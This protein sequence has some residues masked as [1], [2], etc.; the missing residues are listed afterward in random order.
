MSR[1]IDAI[2]L[3]AGKG[4]RVGQKEPKQYLLDKR[5]E[6][7]FLSAL[8]TLLIPPIRKVLLVVP[9]G[10]I[11]KA[12]NLCKNRVDLDK[13]SFVEGSLCREESAYFGL[14]SLRKEAP[15]YVLIHDADR[16]YLSKELLERMLD[17]LEERR[18]IIPVLPSKDSLLVKEKDGSFSYAARERLYRVQ[19]PEL[20]PYRL[21]VDAFE[22]EKEKLPLYT[23]EGSLYLEAGGKIKTVLGEERNEKITTKEDFERWK[24]R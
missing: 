12:G 9:K 1:A 22:K 20:F 5:G 8:K 14:L 15:D 21:L 3:M 6:P 7:L 19:T 24:E 23:D 10:D 13:L 2:L 17:S 16:P 4:V 18:G 11:D